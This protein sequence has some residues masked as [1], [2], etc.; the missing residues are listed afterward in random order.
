MQ[1]RHIKPVNWHSVYPAFKKL[2]RNRKIVDRLVIIIAPVLFGAIIIFWPI[3]VE[4]DVADGNNSALNIQPIVFEIKEGQGLSSIA[5]QLS[6][7][8]MVISRVFFIAYAKI[9]GKEK[10][11]KA[12]KYKLSGSFSTHG[13]IK[14]FSRGLFASNDISVKIPEGF[15][16]NEID[17]R[18]ADIGLIERG[19]L[20]TKNILQQEGYLFPDTYRFPSPDKELLSANK[21]ADKLKDNFDQKTSELF[22]GL[23]SKEKAKAVI[24]ASILEKEVRVYEDMRTVAGI[25][26][27]RFSL[28]M[29]LELDA[30][31]AYG[32]CLPILL[33]GNPCNVAQVNLVDNIPRDSEYNTYERFGL[34]AG[35]ISNPGIKAIQAALNPTNTEYLFYLNAR[36]SG[37]TIFSKTYQE[38]LRARRKYLGL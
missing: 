31:V 34:P 12:G 32:A 37:E 27:R 23:S 21:I 3:S 9:T 14:V 26:E 6:E 4:V 22:S 5:G 20:L 35:P 33:E 15:N 8:N 13:L 7:K 24:V 18:L 29:A 16:I 19:S 25:I 38:H 30:T 17:K 1:K 28:D 2:V 36:G 11:F 10:D